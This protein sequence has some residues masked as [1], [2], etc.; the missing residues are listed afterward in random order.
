MSL[1]WRRGEASHLRRKIKILCHWVLSVSAGLSG[2][3]RK[4]A[5]SKGRKDGPRASTNSDERKVH[6]LIKSCTKQV[7]TVYGNHITPITWF[8][9]QYSR[10]CWCN[11][12]R[13]KGFSI[14]P[15]SFMIAGAVVLT[16]SPITRKPSTQEGLRYFNTNEPWRAFVC[17]ERT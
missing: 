16:V 11:Y 17:L 14:F 12:S 4:C 7:A 2:S 9:F 3:W 10:L 1:G 6:A 13:L 8:D 5:Y 15:T